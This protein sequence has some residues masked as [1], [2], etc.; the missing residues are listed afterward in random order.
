MVSLSNHEGSAPRQ[1]AHHATR[2]ET[3]HRSGFYMA[4]KRISCGKPDHGATA[5]HPH[6]AIHIQFQYLSE[7]RSHP[8]N[9]LS[10]IEADFISIENPGRSGGI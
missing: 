5:I 8:R 4:Q 6:R 3:V 7:R 9:S 2:S 1:T 10:A